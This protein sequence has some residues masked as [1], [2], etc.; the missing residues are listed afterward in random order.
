MGTSCTGTLAAAN[1]VCSSWA[2]CQ[3]TCQKA[4]CQ[5][6]CQSGAACTLD[7][8]N[9]TASQCSIALCSMGTAAKCPD[10]KTWACD[11]VCPAP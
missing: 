4:P 10:G 5:V 1:G 11:A 9:L 3:L 2:S 6:Q 8:G 7:R